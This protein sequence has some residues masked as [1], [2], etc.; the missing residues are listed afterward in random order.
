[1]KH[2]G[3]II[4]VRHVKVEPFFKAVSSVDQHV[5]QDGC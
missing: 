5:K 3:G 2:A 4:G 1:M